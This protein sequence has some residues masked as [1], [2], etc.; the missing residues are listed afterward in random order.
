MN[1]ESWWYKHIGKINAHQYLM[2]TISDW[3]QAIKKT[4]LEHWAKQESCRNSQ[5]S[6]WVASQS[7]YFS[8]LK[9]I[10]WLQFVT[11]AWIFSSG[12][13]M[14]NSDCLF[15]SRNENRHLLAGAIRR[16]WGH[17]S[18][19]IPKYTHTKHCNKISWKKSLDHSLLIISSS[20]FVHTQSPLFFLNL[21]QQKKAKKMAKELP[22][23]IWSFFWRVVLVTKPG[24]S[25]S[26]DKVSSLQVHPKS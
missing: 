5:N 23:R 6:D 16:E 14:Q 12:A 24:G 1:H 20:F 25:T 8:W 11:F 10:Q 21:A 17:E 15:F 7:L 3:C 19:L 2:L 18:K 13:E 4:Y 9:L 22:F 26:N